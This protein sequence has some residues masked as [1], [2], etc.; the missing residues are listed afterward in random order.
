MYW[1][2]PGTGLRLMGSLHL[3]PSGRPELPKWAVD[4]FDWAESLVFEAPQDQELIA[5]TIRAAE[6]ERITLAL[7]DVARATIEG[8]WQTK[9]PNAPIE[10]FKPWAAAL[11]V[12]SFLMETSPGVEPQFTKWAG[13]QRKPVSFLETPASFAAI[14]D[15]ISRTELCASME[16]VAADLL[17]P[18]RNLNALYDAWVAKD[19]EQVLEV[20]QKSP[21]LRLE[22]MRQAL[23]MRRNRAWLERL[24]ELA[25]SSERVLVAVGALHCVGAGNVRELLNRP[26]R[27]V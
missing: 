3:L 17:E 9:C 5:A 8:L 19:F 21:M 10:S 11:A 1:E 14:A 25:Q 4:A 12:P 15:T 23:L 13:E 18:A 16:I 20:A 2:F 26:N 24:T 27:L 7:S 6:P 22:G